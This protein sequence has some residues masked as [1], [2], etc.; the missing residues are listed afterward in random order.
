[1]ANLSSGTLPRSEESFSSATPSR[2]IRTKATS[3]PLRGYATCTTCLRRPTLGRAT[4]SCM[5]WRRTL[6]TSRTCEFRPHNRRVRLWT[7][8]RR[9]RRVRCGAATPVDWFS[10]VCPC[11][12][13]PLTGVG[14]CVAQPL[15]CHLKRTRP[16][17]FSAERGL[18]IQPRDYRTLAATRTRAGA[19]RC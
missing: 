15:S 8:I 14:G 18:A 17:N 7:R 16:H 10:A 9:N 5:R 2:P 6:R 13:L 19:A 4:R 11:A 3:R 1:M 12:F